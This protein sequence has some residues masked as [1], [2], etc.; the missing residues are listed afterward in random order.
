MAV[1]WEKFKWAFTHGAW[2]VAGLVL[3]IDPKHIDAFIQKH[4]DWSGFILGLW[5]LVL[6][7]AN[8]TRPDA[9]AAQR[10]QSKGSSAK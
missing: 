2:F 1:I 3:L 7:W 4:P 8:K 10:M 6:A 5:T 9:A